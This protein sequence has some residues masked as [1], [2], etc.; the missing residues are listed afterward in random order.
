MMDRFRNW[1]PDQQG[2]HLYAQS[3]FRLKGRIPDLHSDRSLG[4]RI[5]TTLM[6]SRRSTKGSMSSYARSGETR[7]LYT[8]HELALYVDLTPFCL[9]KRRGARVLLR[10]RVARRSETLL[11]QLPSVRA[12]RASRRR[13][14][15][16][17]ATPSPCEMNLRRRRRISCENTSRPQSNRDA[18]GHGPGGSGARVYIVSVAEGETADSRGRSSLELS[19]GARSSRRER[20]NARK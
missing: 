1:A 15:G 19:A 8:S 11:V 18:V 17:R 4:Q 6:F 16:G 10:T 14:G 2:I 13:R 7:S 12:R 5:R 20:G 9:S 3:S